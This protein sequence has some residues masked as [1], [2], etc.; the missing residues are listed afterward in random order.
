M[1]RS[2]MSAVASRT[3]RMM[4]RVPQDSISVQS[5]QGRKAVSL[6]QGKAASGPSMIR[7][8]DPMV[9]VDGGRLRQ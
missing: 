5:S 4:I 7:I 8:R 9:T 6:A 1:V 2:K 3:W